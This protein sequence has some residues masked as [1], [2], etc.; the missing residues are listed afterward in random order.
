M[1]ELTLQVAPKYVKRYQS[2][3]PLVQREMIVNWPK[4]I[5]EGQILRLVSPNK[6]FLGKAYY[7]KQNK[8]DGWVFSRK[9][10]ET[11]STEFFRALLQEAVQNRQELFHDDTTTA[12]RLFNGEGDGLGGLT[13]DY[14]DGFLLLQWYSAG[15]YSYQKALLRAMFDQPFV[16]GIYEKKRFLREEN[17]HDFVGG[18]VP[19]F[20][21]LVKENGMTYATYLNDG[22]MTGIFLD[23]RNV[24]RRIMEEF[25]SQKNVL[26]TFS[27]TGAFS[28]AA[29]Y[30]GALNTTSV[31]VAKRSVAKT[32]EQFVVNGFN[33]E[34]Q[35]ILV[36]DVFEYMKFAKRKNMLFDLVIADPP[37]FARTKKITFSVAKDYGTLMEE[38]ISITA[39]NGTIIASTNYA[40]FSLKKFKEIISAAFKESKR[41]F[42]IRETHTLPSD[43]KVH[44]EFPEGNY[45]KV[46]ILEL[47]I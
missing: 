23:Q 16:K 6:A 14:Y 45:L 29:L 20:P 1:E 26:N 31:D 19:E 9:E 4:Q 32:S 21:L 36:W 10:D 11:L 28:V 25:A 17:T 42:K 41:T 18:D 8:G 46:L 22:W 43:F 40:N 2:G 33:P 47:D 24:R 15:I 30:G 12:F 7:G 13:I 37:S 38:L 39:P 34:E 35:S 5:A 44:P 27:Y 3:F